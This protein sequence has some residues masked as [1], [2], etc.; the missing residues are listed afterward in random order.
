MEILADPTVIRATLIVVR[1]LSEDE[2]RHGEFG[3]LYGGIAH[4]ATDA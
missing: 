1:V 3:S 4:L 2:P